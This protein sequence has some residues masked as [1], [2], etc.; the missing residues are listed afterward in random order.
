[1]AGTADFD[2]LRDAIAALTQERGWTRN[3]LFEALQ[4]ETRGEP[5]VS[6]PTFYRWFDRAAAV[7]PSILTCVPYLS[8]IFDVP[9]HV[10][11][12]AAKL[13]PAE[14]VSALALQSASR[15]MREAAYTALRAVDDS[16]LPARGEG[17][18]LNRLIAEPMGYH[19]VVLPLFRGTR[20]TLHLRSWIAFYPGTE[21]PQ[22]A[23]SR[24]RIA[25][26]LRPPRLREYVR[27]EVVG[28]GL[29]RSLGLRWRD[30]VPIE[31]DRHP[32]RPDLVLELPVEERNRPRPGAGSRHLGS[33]RILVLSALWGHFEPMVAMLADALRWGSTD[34]RNH[35]FSFTDAGPEKIAFCRESLRDVSP[36]YVWALGEPGSVMR[37]LAPAIV[38]AAPAHHVVWV[39]Y[40]PAFARAAAEAF[41]TRADVIRASQRWT[42]AVVARINADRAVL[43]VDYA[44]DDVVSTRSDGATFLDR[45]L[46]ADHVRYSTA[47]ILTALRGSGGPSIDSWGP[48]FT[49]L[50]R[51]GSPSAHVPQRRTSVRW[52]P[53]GSVRA[54]RGTR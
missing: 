44:D 12:R 45:N 46:I 11:Y 10:F 3:R 24:T 36:H 19:Y 8:D 42:H 16:R 17:Q 38:A 23:G 53:P 41:A 49:D 2:A 47:E 9:D 1:M 18:V 4:R 25:R 32:G 54:D 28:D 14:E 6:R 50:V 31:L 7:G 27:H 29:W 51:S 35:G 20:I 33:S 52:L 30:P 34:V 21:A 48:R 43:H 40:G 37:A 22:Q 13:L 5:P 39:T 26:D 15:T